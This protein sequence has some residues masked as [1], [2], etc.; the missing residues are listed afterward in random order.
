LASGARCGLIG[1]IAA[2]AKLARKKHQ[3]NPFRANW[4]RLTVKFQRYGGGRPGG[5]HHCIQKKV[6]ALLDEWSNAQERAAKS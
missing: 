6:A 1:S 5:S 3:P 4:P 2:A